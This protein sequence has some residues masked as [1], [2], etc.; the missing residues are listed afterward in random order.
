MVERKEYARRRRRVMEALDDTSVLIAPTAPVLR[1]NRDVEFPFRPDSDFYYLT[2]FAEPEA[3][4]VLV[5]GRPQGEYLLFCREHDP[6]ME[7]WVGRCAGLDQAIS[8]FGADDAF[9]MSDLDDILPGIME[10]R[11]RVYYSMGN[12]ADFDQRVLGWLG[13]LRHRGHYSSGHAEIVSPDHIIHDLRLVKSAAEVRVVRQA[14]A[15]SAHAHRHAMAVCE[16]GMPEYEL[17]A[18]LLR[19]FARHGA[20][21]SAYPSIVAGG[22]NG[23]I[24]HYTH[25]DSRLNDGDLVLIDA[26]AEFDYYAADIT[27]TFPVGGTFSEPQRLLY[28]TVLRAQ[29]AAIAEVYPG[30]DF[31]A[32]HRTAVRVIAQ[33][34][35]EL[36]L[37]DGPLDRVLRDGDYERYYMHPT[38][39][40]LGLD[41]HDVGEYK[42]GGA[43]RVFEPGMITTVEPGLYISPD[44]DELGRRWR[45]IA[46]RIEDDVLV[47]RDGPEV[48]TAAV[49]K[50]VAEVEALCLG[51]TEAVVVS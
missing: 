43:W 30:N 44:A 10:G 39:H 33:G 6:Q 28:E 19:E 3:V 1:R 31:N 17:E 22:A 16:P 50:S 12:Y 13:I 29:E 15:A 48:L 9:P 4:A 2:G 27:R 14:V 40:W 42:L 7:R 36:G 18:E 26:G 5:P 41:V 34:L 24:M 46:I 37:L 38:G 8:R 23:C 35:I 25:N 51:Y 11:A 49:P 45:G 47:T 32:P 21:H 20:R